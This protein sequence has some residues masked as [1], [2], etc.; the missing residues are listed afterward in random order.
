LN[1]YGQSELPPNNENFVA[2]AGGEIHSLGLKSDGTIVAWGGN[3]SGQC[4]V[5]LPN[6]GFVAIASGSF[7]NLGLKSDGTIVAWGDNKEGQSTVPMSNGGFVAVAAGILHSLGLKSDGSIVA[8]GN[9]YFGQCDVPLPNGG[10]VAVAACNYHSLGLKSDGS[11]VAWG[12]DQVGESEVP[13]PNGGFVAIAAGYSHSLGLKSD[14]SIVGWGLNNQ[15]ECDAPLPNEG[16]VAVSGGGFH[17][18]G[19]KALAPVATL[20]QNFS[21]SLSGSC[22]EIKW[23]LSVRGAGMGFHVLRA[24][25]AS[26]GFEELAV[27][28]G[29]GLSFGYR[30]RSCEP[31]VTYRYRVDVEDKG[32]MRT[33]FET[34]MLS[35]PAMPLTLNQNHP[36]P[37]NPS[38]VISYYV[39]DECLVTLDIYDSSGRHVSRLLDQERQPRGTH[40]V[41]WRG[42][43]AGGTAVASGVYFCRL[44]TG[45]ETLS[46]KMLLLR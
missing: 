23:T 22:M 26:G 17:S 3:N 10:F 46:R 28:S 40:S 19:L 45:K 37:F 34:E 27:I 12:T 41:E 9:N 6:G 24:E 30:D 1:Q 20:L 29:E 13:L 2:V 16:F 11:I 44:H 8:W 42:S 18:L 5:P 15:G 31:G 4:D 38:T 33:L 39:P 25:G 32:A 14:G 36:N 43:N 35:V 7:H 21:T